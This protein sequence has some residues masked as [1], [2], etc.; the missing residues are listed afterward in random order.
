MCNQSMSVFLDWRNKQVFWIFTLASFDNILSLLWTLKLV[1]LLFQWV[2]SLQVCQLCLKYLFV[3]AQMFIIEHNN[4]WQC[5][6]I[7]KYFFLF[8]CFMCCLMVAA[9]LK[10][11]LL[12][13]LFLRSYSWFWIEQW[14]INSWVLF[15]L[16]EITIFS[17]CN[18]SS[19]IKM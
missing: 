10:I 14:L 19:C 1:F 3:W 6:I 5:T 16:H 15:H 8:P 4:K 7:F 12:E 17:G 11:Y 2:W 9:W 13:C 18:I